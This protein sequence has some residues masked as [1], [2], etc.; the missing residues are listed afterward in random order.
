MDLEYDLLLHLFKLFSV[1]P[2]NNNLDFIMK[3]KTISEI[4]A[5]WKEDKKQYVKRSTY[6]LYAL[7]LQNH[8]LPAF[9]ELYELDEKTVQEFIFHKISSG[10][11][12]KT[13][14]D[15]LIVLKMIMKF[16]AKNKF[17][18]YQVWDIKFPTEREKQELEVL[19]IC[20]QKKLMKFINE[21]FT[22]KN[23]G[24]Y[25]CLSAGLRI[26]EICALAWNDIDVDAGV[27]YVRKTIERIYIIEG[28]DRHT[29]LIIGTPKTK[30]SI[31]EIPMTGD[32]M[33]IIKPLKR[34]VNENF[35]VLT[36]EIKPIEPRTYRNYYNKLMKKLNIPKLKFHG[37]RHSFA[38]RCIESNCDYKTVSVILG[39]SNISTTLNLY[40]H[41]NMEQKKK[42]IDKM[43]KAIR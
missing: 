10:L 19:S 20:N 24:I 15:I 25:I 41:P 23:L 39:H 2:D 26:G 13:I 43:F 42:C 6:S 1:L 4:S 33:K 37:L 3:K 11:S 29:E 5:L 36:N 40:V 31:R 22:F 38:T 34:V 16:G 7:I 35:F 12:N 28:S 32:M 21:N 9:G 14:K 18:E 30:N 8:I 27:I 17:I